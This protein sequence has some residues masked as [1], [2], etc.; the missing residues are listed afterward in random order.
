MPRHEPGSPVAIDGDRVL[1]ARD[2]ATR[3]TVL[4]EAFPG[5]RAIVCLC[6]D[7]THVATLL[8]T[9]LLRNRPCV[10]P[11]D[12]A[13]ET[14][15]RLRDRYAGAVAVAEGERAG[16]LGATAIEPLVAGADADPATPASTRFAAD[17]CAA[18]VFTS[19]STGEPRVHAK[20][21]G[22]LTASGQALRRRFDIGPGHRVV[23]TVPGQ[24]VYG[25]EASIMLP[26]ATG[27]AMFPGQPL[28][29]ADIAAAL[30]SAGAPRILVSTP[31]QLRRVVDADDLPIPALE[32][33]ISATAPLDAG[34]AA[35]IEQRLHA[36][37]VEMYGSTETG[38]VATRRTIEDD[39]WT[40][41]PGVSIAPDD[42]GCIVTT[43][44]LPAPVR[45]GDRIEPLGP[46]RFRLAGRSEDLV[47][48]AGKRGSLDDI[49]NKLLA[50]DGVRDAAVFVPPEEV[51]V[52]HR[53]AA[54]VVAPGLPVARILEDLRARLDP[55][56][57]PRPLVRVDHLPRGPTGKIARADLERLYHDHAGRCRER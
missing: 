27:G 44:N 1:A 19:G 23:A 53:P 7:R 26:L 6:A 8:L 56:F 32:L 31:V 15:Q 12:H 34:L 37:V 28:L 5:D 57:L 17:R 52:V 47:K 18:H 49:V 55:V 22:A 9:G 51:A 40:R 25:L 14:L 36:P 54:F 16:R 21:W 30:E 42:D 20:P 50:I 13:P 45:L 35:R 33:V 24:H 10:M 29:P 43:R 2:L 46:D 11:H 3:A 4:A 39:A 41:V 38:L 48:I